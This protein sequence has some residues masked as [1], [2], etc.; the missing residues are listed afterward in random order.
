LEPH[1]NH[2]AQPKVDLLAQ[3]DRLEEMILDNPRVPLTGKTMVDEEQLIAQIDA[4]RY[5]IP[6]ALKIA[7]EIIDYQERIVREAQQKAQEIIATAND[8]AYRI[9]NDLGIIDRAEQ[10]ARQIRQTAIVECE[11]LKQQTMVEVEKIRTRTLEEI[12][13]MRQEAIAECQE[14]QV[15]ADEYAD[16]VL[17]QI[18][19]QLNG[20]LQVVQRGRSQL[21]Q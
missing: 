6:E 19:D 18:E 20:M 9:V 5:S 17:H 2:S 13:Q 21:Q 14:I 11:Q 16:R 3:L 12:Q 10:E 15:G 8:R 1:Q 4:I 7:R